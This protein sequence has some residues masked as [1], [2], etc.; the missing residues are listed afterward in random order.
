MSVSSKSSVRPRGRRRQPARAAAP[1]AVGVAVAEDIK[2]RRVEAALREGGLRVAAAAGGPEALVAE[3]EGCAAP[4]DVVV[5]LVDGSPAAQAASV[6]TVRD[7]LN[8]VALVIVSPSE[9]AEAAREALTAGAEGVVLEAEVDAALP[10]VVRVVTRGQISFPRALHTNVGNPV[11]STREKQVLGM[12]V[13]GFSNAEI[14]DRLYLAES[15]VKSHLRSVFRKLGVRSRNEAAALVLD[16]KQG[17]G[18]G[19]LKISHDH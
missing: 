1:I 5:L 19:I 17:L 9:R 18:T 16:S 11:F 3:I 6:R 12:V 14:A 2:R 15:T 7:R 4:V 10:A 8:R 13:M